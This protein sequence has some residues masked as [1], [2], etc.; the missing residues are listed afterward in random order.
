M[1]ALFVLA[2]LVLCLLASPATMVNEASAAPKESMSIKLEKPN[3]PAI[4]DANQL[5]SEAK[6]G[7]E[8][9]VSKDLGGALTNL[10]NAAAADAGATCKA[11]CSIETGGITCP[12]GQ[13]CYC[14]CPGGYA[15]CGCKN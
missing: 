1:K 10:L 7:H 8:I 15:S 2:V 4:T 9:R 6:P 13:Q 12:V 14:G 3:S 5:P 11:E